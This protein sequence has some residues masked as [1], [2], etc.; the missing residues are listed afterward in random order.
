MADENVNENVNVITD[1]TASV[2]TAPENAIDETFV[3]PDPVV[4]SAPV[5]P[6]V[7]TSTFA[8]QLKALEDE[9]AALEADLIAKLTKKKAAL[10]GENA[11]VDMDLSVL[12]SLQ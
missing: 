10:Q 5:L 8:T 7:S 3:V 2:E 1:A 12:G 11:Q 4:V 9:I 6:P